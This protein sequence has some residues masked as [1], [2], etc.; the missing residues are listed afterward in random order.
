MLVYF[1]Q[2]Y[3]LPGFSSRLKAWER[4][5]LLPLPMANSHMSIGRPNSTRQIR[6][7]NRK[8]P[9]PFC[10]QMYGNFHTLPRPMAHP[11]DT[12]I[13]PNRDWKVALFLFSFIKNSPVNLVGQALLYSI[14]WLLSNFHKVSYYYAKTCWN[15]PFKYTKAGCQGRRFLHIWQNILEYL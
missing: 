15:K 5:R 10:P 7:R 4:L 11:A 14:S 2:W 12:S 13:N 9:P 1:V 6:Y 3:R 8:A